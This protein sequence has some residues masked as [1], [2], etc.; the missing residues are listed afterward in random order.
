ML[1]HD[2]DLNFP[3]CCTCCPHLQAVKAS[4]THELRQSLVRELTTEQACPVYSREKTTAMRH[5]TDG[6]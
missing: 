6:R 1:T 5:L 2:A 3:T 4:C